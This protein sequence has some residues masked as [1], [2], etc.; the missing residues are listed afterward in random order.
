MRRSHSGRARRRPS[1]ALTFLVLA[2]ALVLFFIIGG[3]SEINNVSGAYNRA[4]QG[5][6]Q[7][8]AAVVADQ[9]N[10]LGTQLEN[11]LITMPQ[12]DRITLESRLGALAREA[13]TDET[14]AKGLANPISK[15]Q[16]KQTFVQVM[17]YRASALEKIRSGVDGLLGLQSIKAFALDS[18]YGSS[19]TRS[20]TGSNLQQLSLVSA[21]QDLVAASALLSKADQRY[22]KLAGDLKALL[23]SSKLPKSVWGAASQHLSL[24]SATPLVSSLASSSSL[25]PVERLVLTTVRVNPIAI[26]V[27]S[28][29][30]VGLSASNGL[31]LPP[32][33]SVA[34]SPVV[35]N[36]GNMVVSNAKV[37]LS[38][39][40]LT[41][42]VT[43]TVSRYVS[44]APNRSLTLSSIGFK[45]KPGQSYQLTVS[46]LP[47][48]EQVNL[49]STQFQSLIQIAPS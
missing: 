4:T 1:P 25:A 8:Q 44:L 23:G 47:P 48:S 40:G 43:K 37:T 17:S 16:L 35:S 39:T 36:E 27:P 15:N 11:L 33:S 21:A 32:T 19:P 31:V 18:T 34:L 5:S 22:A 45:T 42:N 7:V 24:S 20:I 28:T 30:T 41:G 14:T 29:S 26:P 2:I 3:I 38:F 6:F 9:S 49:S 46:I 10:L 13:S 12:L